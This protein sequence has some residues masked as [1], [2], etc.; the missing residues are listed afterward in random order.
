MGDSKLKKLIR[1]INNHINDLLPFNLD[2]NLQYMSLSQHDDI[3]ALDLKYQ[4]KLIYG[5]PIHQNIIINE[6][7]ALKTSLRYLM[8]KSKYLLK[9]NKETPY[10]DILYY[11]SKT[12]AEIVTVLCCSLGVYKSKYLQRCLILQKFKIINKDIVNRAV[13]FTKFKIGYGISLTQNK[14]KIYKQTISDLNKTL[15]FILKVPLKDV[16]IASPLFKR[17]LEY[18]FFNP[19]LEEAFDKTLRLPF[20]WIFIKFIEIYD[21]IPFLLLLKQQKIKNIYIPWFISPYISLYQQIISNLNHH[22]YSPELVYLWDLN[23]RRR[24]HF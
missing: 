9:I 5:R 17:K 1:K 19:F 14:H 15:S 3:S 10:Y 16:R 18:A 7:R 13:K 12:Y 20:K 11:C 24:Y 21:C 22:K 8:A 2:V 4:T 6:H 23:A